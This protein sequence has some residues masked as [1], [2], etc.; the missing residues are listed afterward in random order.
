MAYK[1]IRWQRTRLFVSRYVMSLP[2]NAAHTHA[3]QW[4]ERT[5][6]R[7]ATGGWCCGGVLGVDVILSLNGDITDGLQ[8]WPK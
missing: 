5:L 4:F 7:L 3:T 1:A 8:V 2:I 6:R